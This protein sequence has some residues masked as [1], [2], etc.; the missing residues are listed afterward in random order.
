MFFFFY[1]SELH[2]ALVVVILVGHSLKLMGKMMKKTS[3]FFSSFS[4]KINHHEESN[5]AS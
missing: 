3:L 5:I 4:R 1:Q 2:V